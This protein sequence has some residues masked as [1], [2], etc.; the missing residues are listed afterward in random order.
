MG[1]STGQ[2]AAILSSPKY[3]P[4][5][6]DADVSAYITSVYAAGSTI[7]QAAA[8]LFTNFVTGLKADSL[9]SM[10]NNMTVFMGP[11]SLSGAVKPLKGNGV[12]VT[13]Y[14]STDYAYNAG[15]HSSTSSK[16]LKDTKSLSSLSNAVFGVYYLNA[17]TAGRSIASD[18]ATNIGGNI[19]LSTTAT[20]LVQGKICT[21]TNI[22]TSILSGTG[23]W[24]I[25]RDSGTIYIRVGGIEASS[26]PSGT[27][28]NGVWIHGNSSNVAA[29]KPN[30]PVCGYYI[31]NG[32]AD[33][34]Q[35]DRANFASRW[36][37]LINSLA[38]L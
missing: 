15:I 13:G 32:G 25:T 14:V 31:G 22:I 18:V 30:T 27:N 29:N 36:D 6:S 17:P 23:L 38:Y 7:S 3:G 11:S 21:S 37:T 9:W 24:Q 4:T 35:S 34:T 19:A 2:L 12:T 28:T 1:I 8:D 5:S 33:T 20:S 10:I 16:K 26:S